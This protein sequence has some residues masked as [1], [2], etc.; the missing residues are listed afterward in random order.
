M[1]LFVNAVVTGLAIGSVYGLIAL[2]YTLVFNATR[3]F[4]LAQGDL[5]MLGVLISFWVLDIQHWPE[6]AALLLVLVAVPGVSLVEERFVVRP[7]LSRPSSNI[8]WFISTLAFSLVVET[9]VIILYGN[10]PPEPVPSPLSSHAIRFG[11]ISLSPQLFVAI[12]SIIVVT[13][14]VELFYH[15]TWLGRA[16]R[17]SAD[18][19]EVAALR[20]IS[21]I[22][23]SRLAFLLGG[24]VAAIGGFVIAPVVFAN[25]SIGLSYSLKGFIALAVGGF[26]SI[27][28]A[29]IGSWALGIAE[30][31]FDLYANPQYEVVAGLVL[32]MLIL[33]VRPTGIFGGGEVR[34]V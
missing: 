20:G 26:G 21:P 18:D 7:F 27:R 29:L 10:R 8:G 2:G 9:V 17:A 5:V 19:R 16:M 6:L 23:I 30:Q 14:L 32:L 1:D 31:L 11:S 12:L 25:V 24:V 3:V 22:L 4:N 34:Q 13:V 28:G 33:A 15:R